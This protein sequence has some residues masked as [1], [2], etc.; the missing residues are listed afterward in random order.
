MTTN[1]IP[2]SNRR[3]RPPKYIYEY[4]YFGVV[5]Q[6]RTSSVDAVGQESMYVYFVPLGLSRGRVILQNIYDN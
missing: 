2:E 6:E 3:S 4:V 5:G 1:H